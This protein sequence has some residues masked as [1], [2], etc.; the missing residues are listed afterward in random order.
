MN[1]R[2]LSNFRVLSGV[3]AVYS[4]AVFQSRQGGCKVKVKRGWSLGGPERRPKNLQQTGW[5]RSLDRK[6]KP[7]HLVFILFSAQLDTEA[8]VYNSDV[9]LMC[10]IPNV[11]WV[12][13]LFE[14][15]RHP[16]DHSNSN[17]NISHNRNNS[18]NSN[19]SKH[20]HMQVVHKG[21][22][23]TGRH[24]YLESEACITLSATPET[25]KSM[26]PALLSIA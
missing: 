18:N 19:N 16:H 8:L 26:R 6:P 23:G 2:S 13:E 24:V 22:S 20:N 1:C 10:M 17:S 25:I 21:K 4:Q 7:H 12:A 9:S 14:E 3:F 15:D 5:T 11:P